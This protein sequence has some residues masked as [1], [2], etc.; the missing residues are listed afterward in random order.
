MPVAPPV[1]D[2]CGYCGGRD[3][4]T[5]CEECN[6]MFYCSA[7]H[8]TLDRDLHM[9]P[10]HTITGLR[11]KVQEERR[12][13]A[14]ELYDGAICVGEGLWRMGTKASVALQM[15]EYVEMVR[16]DRD[17]FA[18]LHFLIPGLMLRVGQ[19]QRCYDYL[20]WWA[21]QGQAAAR[22]D[23]VA[24]SDDLDECESGGPSTTGRG[25][26]KTK[27]VSSSIV[28]ENRAILR[29]TDHTAL[30]RKL[31]EQVRHLYRIIDR[32]NPHFWECLEKEPPVPDEDAREDK[33][34]AYRV[35]MACRGILARLLE[36]RSFQ[37]IR[38]GMQQTS[39]TR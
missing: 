39:Q 1:T 5:P 35:F 38:A 30:I 37:K 7:E 33:E 22:C 14:I 16:L 36:L 21:S 18:E 9:T 32:C 25:K 10:C 13:R 3:A 23:E 8:G 4:R 31:T 29:G 28:L 12:V 15:E 27:Y 26:S 11:S 20:K 2:A 6:V 34:W 17:D 24:E 19:D